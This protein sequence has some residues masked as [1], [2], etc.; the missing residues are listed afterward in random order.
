MYL[1]KMNRRPKLSHEHAESHTILE[2]EENGD[3]EDKKDLR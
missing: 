3:I 2:N 1:I